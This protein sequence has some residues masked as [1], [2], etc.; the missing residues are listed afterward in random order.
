MCCLPGSPTS[1]TPS[2]TAMRLTSLFTWSS[3]NRNFSLGI[4]ISFTPS[5]L[6]TGCR[7]SD[8]L[9]L[10]SWSLSSASWTERVSYTTPLCEL[11]REEPQYIL[12]FLLQEHGGAAHGGRPPCGGTSAALRPGEPSAATPRPLASRRP[13]SPRP[14]G[15]RAWRTS[16]FGV[17]FQREVSLGS[18]PMENLYYK[19]GLK[20]VG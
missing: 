5:V 4:G 11:P 7:S 20:N 6:V 15:P 3:V 17:P 8:R 12:A 16:I 1:S 10:I 14:P 2:G 18:K 19:F 13:H 9:V